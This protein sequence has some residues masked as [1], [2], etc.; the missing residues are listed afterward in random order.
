MLVY[1]VSGVFFPLVF[2]QKMSFGAP[3]CQIWIILSTFWWPSLRAA[4]NSSKLDTPRLICPPENSRFMPHKKVIS[5]NMLSIPHCWWFR[6][7]APVEVGSSPHSAGF[8]PLTGSFVGGKAAPPLYLFNLRET[9]LLLFKWDGSSTVGRK[10]G[11]PSSGARH[12]RSTAAWR[13]TCARPRPSSCEATGP[14]LPLWGQRPRWKK[15]RKP[16]ET[17]CF[18]KHF[19]R[20]LRVNGFFPV[21]RIFLL[22][23]GCPVASKASKNVQFWGVKSSFLNT[24]WHCLSRLSPFEP[25]DRTLWRWWHHFPAIIAGWHQSSNGRQ[26]ELRK[27]VGS[28]KVA[29]HIKPAKKKNRPTMKLMEVPL[30][31]I[32]LWKSIIEVLNVQLQ[33]RAPQKN[34]PPNDGVNSSQWWPWHH[35]QLSHSFQ[36][37]SVKPD[38]WVH[39]STRASD[40]FFAFQKK[41][42]SLQS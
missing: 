14:S 11:L 35:V 42:R 18:L 33:R 29:K 20:T 31:A 39:E 1:W 34:L 41:T 4:G 37:T 15:C 26:N 9:G 5:W 16:V 36:S 10:L 12:C 22:K 28:F 24:Y 6:N 17:L 30:Q 13:S 23:R 38:Q 3:I 40:W 25:V 27:P 8:L 7:P 19:K 32:F 21:P 2:G